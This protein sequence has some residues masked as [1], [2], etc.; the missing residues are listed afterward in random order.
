VEETGMNSVNPSRMPRRIAVISR[1]MG[2]FHE[3]RAGQVK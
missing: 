1:L 2:A 3:A